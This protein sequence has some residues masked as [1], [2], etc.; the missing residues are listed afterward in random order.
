[1]AETND[2]MAHG[3]SLPRP[4]F[5]SLHMLDGN[6]FPFESNQ[7]YH[8]PA[9]QWDA[10]KDSAEAIKPA[11]SWFVQ[12]HY[13]FQV[14]RIIALERYYNGDNDIHY[15]CSDKPKDR[16]DN[17]IQSGLPRYITNIRVGYQFGNPIKFG[18][19]S[20]GDGD[21]GDD[22]LD[23]IDTF[24][25]QNDESYHEKVMAKNLNNTG[26]AYELVYAEEGSNQIKMRAIDPA[27][28]F[29]VYDTTIERH[30]LFAVRYYLIDF[31]AT[32]TFYVEVYTDDHV[33]YFKADN[34][35]TADY[36][37]TD[38]TEHYFGA[39]PVT[40]YN[41]NDER[42]GTWEV[43]LD[44]IDAYDKSLSEMANSQEDFG[45]AILVISGDI[46]NG[47]N[48][49]DATPLLNA[50]GE[51]MYDPDHHPLYKVDKIDPTQRTMFLK[52]SVINDPSGGTVVV[53]TDA[54]YLTK[55]LNATDWETYVNRVLADIHKDTNTPDVTDQNFAANASGVAMAYK[56]W[57]SDQERTNQ[58]SLYTRGIMRRLRLCGT[59]WDFISQI[60]SIDDIEK[61]EITYTPNL[62]KN[63]AETVANIQALA[64]TG[65][66]SAQT[67]QEKAETI[68]GVPMDQE[69]Q[70]MDDERKADAQRTADMMPQ[71]FTDQEQGGL[72]NG[73]NNANKNPAKD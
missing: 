19:S 12:Q 3:M 29:V 58:E 71:L 57:G 20:D 5:N 22:L 45:N 30:S 59:Y 67:I 18:Y 66:I 60:S 72:N 43:K 16:A 6:R 41:L 50:D 27:N 73:D 7:Q 39:V 62:P 31:M 64:A 1:M 70:R 53:P 61:I 51:Q 42:I 4:S 23:T 13:A 69:Q 65:D 54:K 48:P 32:S 52:A 17:R 28:C 9:D 14:P 37:L 21:T 35:P 10:I 33:Y 55:E 36:T 56:L 15:W 38:Q 40:E 26:R 25:S 68:T 8:M 63:D 46:E 11:L 2:L 44:E 34:S 47:M 24:N 49:Q